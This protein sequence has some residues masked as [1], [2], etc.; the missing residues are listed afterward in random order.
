MNYLP[1]LLIFGSIVAHSARELNLIDIKHLTNIEDSTDVEAMP[2]SDFYQ[3]VCGKWSEN[4]PGY[5]NVYD[6]INYDVNMELI[7]YMENTRLTDKPNF[8]NI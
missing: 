3:H 8:V 4:N 1:V 7:K 6:K 2:C 5:D